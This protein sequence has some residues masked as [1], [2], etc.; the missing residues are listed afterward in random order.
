MARLRRMLGS[1]DD[2]DL[3]ESLVPFVQAASIQSKAALGPESGRPIP[4]G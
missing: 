4:R 3:D 1:S 2:S